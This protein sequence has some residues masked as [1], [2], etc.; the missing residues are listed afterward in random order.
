MMMVDELT[1]P[2]ALA[3]LA[4]G[5]ST[6]ELTAAVAGTGAPRVAHFGR[7]GASQCHDGCSG[8]RR[9][10]PGTVESHRGRMYEQLFPG[11]EGKDKRNILELNR[12]MEACKLD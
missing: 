2:I 9:G 7:A 5:P 1:Y 3:P 10:A 12:M 6:P 8:A 4:G 11:Q